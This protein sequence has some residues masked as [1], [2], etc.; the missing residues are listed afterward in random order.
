[1]NTNTDQSRRRK[2]KIYPA[3]VAIGP[4]E[5][6]VDAD[7]ESA[8]YPEPQQRHKQRCDAD[9][10]TTADLFVTMCFFARLGFIQ[11]PTCLK[12]AYRSSGCGANA[13]KKELTTTS[14]TTCN[15]LVPWRVDASIPLHPDKL[16]GNVVFI[17]CDTASSLVNGDAY[18]SIRWDTM[19]KCL[20]ISERL[21]CER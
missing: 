16:E 12:C 21:P 2:R 8:C 15:N 14:L 19:K 1:M 20:I 9:N 11:P 5:V 17:T 13:H 7:A 3:G 10:T 6:F 4:S 18:P